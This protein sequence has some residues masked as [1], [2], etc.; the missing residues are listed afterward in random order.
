[1][2]PPRNPTLY[3]FSKSLFDDALE[4]TTESEKK[5]PRSAVEKDVEVTKHAVTTLVTGEEV[6]KDVG[7]A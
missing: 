7:L 3:P 4:K 6:A 1:M 2:P 5:G